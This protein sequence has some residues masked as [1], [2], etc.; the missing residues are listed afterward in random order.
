MTTITSIRSTS[1]ETP[2][3]SYS[4]HSSDGKIFIETIQKTHKTLYP[5]LRVAGNLSRATDGWERK[6]EWERPAIGTMFD[7]RFGPPPAFNDP[8]QKKY[9]EV[10]RAYMRMCL[11]KELRRYIKEIAI[12]LS[13]T[14]YKAGVRES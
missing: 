10:K 4:E 11:R 8:K 3:R 9:L 13:S 12:P 14:K 1:L 5:A 7:R 2:K 6:A